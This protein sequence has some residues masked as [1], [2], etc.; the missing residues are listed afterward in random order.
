MNTA[1]MQLAGFT[2]ALRRTDRLGRIAGDRPQAVTHR[3]RG[4][5]YTIATPHRS[6]LSEAVTNE[7]L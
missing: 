4:R 2:A 6:R 1:V 7:R 3:L 5:G